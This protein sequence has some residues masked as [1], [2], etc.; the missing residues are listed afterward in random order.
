MADREILSPNQ[1]INEDLHEMLGAFPEPSRSRMLKKIRHDRDTA[2]NNPTENTDSNAR[3][4][5]REFLVAYELLKYGL[6][7]EYSRNLSGQTPDWYADKEKILLEVFTCERGGT[8]NL[9]R[10]VIDGIA[11]KTSKYRSLI[12]SNSLHFLVGIHG[13]IFSGFDS[14]CCE[15]VMSDGNHNNLLTGIIFFSETFVDKTI[16]PDGSIRRKQRYSFRFFPNHSAA[17]PFDLSFLR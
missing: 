10:R 5:F 11:E 3:H 13:D 14:H 6:L 17:R 9:V 7:L 2:L 8:S 12:E 16:L 1:S 15:D 4:T